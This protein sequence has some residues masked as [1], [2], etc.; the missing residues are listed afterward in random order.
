MLLVITIAI[1]LATCLATSDA[2]SAFYSNAL[3]F[4][5]ILWI[6]IYGFVSAVA[7]RISGKK[8]IKISQRLEARAVCLLLLVIVAFLAVSLPLFPLTNHP[9]PDIVAQER[10]GAEALNNSVTYLYTNH[11]G[12]GIDYPPLY[13]YG[14]Y[15]NAWL[16]YQLVHSVEPGSFSF[17]VVSKTIPLL[18]N[19]TIGILL[20]S[21]LRR[22]NAIAAIVGAALYLLNPAIIFDTSYVG[23]VDSVYTLFLFLTLRCLTGRKYFLSMLYASLAVLTKLQSLFLIPVVAL[24]LIT[25]LAPKR[26]INVIMKDFAAI[27]TVMLPFI[28]SGTLGFVTDTVLHSLNEYPHLSINAFNFWWPLG[29]Y[30]VYY[31]SIYYSI[32]SSWQFSLSDAT[33]IFG[34]PLRTIALAVFAA[35]TALVLYQVRKDRGNML[36]GSTSL[37]FAFFMLPTE[38]HERYLF[39]FFALIIPLAL[40]KRRYLLVYVVLTVT[41]LANMLVVFTFEDTSMYINTM[42]HSLFYF[43]SMAMVMCVWSLPMGLYEFCFVISIVNS[44]IFLYF[45]RVGIFKRLTANLHQDLTRIIL[46]RRQALRIESHMSANRGASLGRENSS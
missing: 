38:I 25:E 34:L 6:A 33:E 16:N 27:T 15:F 18:C 11:S 22:K 30:N 46:D 40:E 9:Y 17:G 35:F 5:G 2:W 10:W 13:M 43:V 20:F 28:V 32:I 45:V 29:Y 7:F 1:V 21:W 39:P 3:E 19:L 8:S 36:L 12:V 4:T 44:V 31:S 23:Q 26:L 24:V 41:Y 42:P 37:A 14:L